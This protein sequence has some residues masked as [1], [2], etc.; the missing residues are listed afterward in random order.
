MAD[1]VV[2]DFPQDDGQQQVSA[3]GVVEPVE[4]AEEKPAQQ[5]GKFLRMPVVQPI[6]LHGREAAAG[7][8]AFLTGVG[9]G[10]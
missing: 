6:G 4:V 1:V 7:G 10:R 9:H 5:H 3:E 2:R 8:G